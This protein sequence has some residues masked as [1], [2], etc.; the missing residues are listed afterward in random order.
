M[1]TDALHFNCPACGRPTSAPMSSVGQTFRC[2]VCAAWIVVPGTSRAPG[3]AAPSSPPSHDS[4]PIVLMPVDYPP[5]PAPLQQPPPPVQLPA[6]P[7][8]RN[9]AQPPIQIDISAIP[10]LRN[11]APA[12]KESRKL[13]GLAHKP[14]TTFGHAFGGSFGC[15]FGFYM[16]I[17]ASMIV[18]VIIAAIFGA[19]AGK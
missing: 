8:P 1:S 19:F 7:A 5:V 15:V 2:S 16:A 4:D 6:K 10:G 11:R 13:Y 18:I 12:S 9:T 17:V 3:V 14:G